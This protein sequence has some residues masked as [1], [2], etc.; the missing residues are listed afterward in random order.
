VTKLTDENFDPLPTEMRIYFFRT[1][2][3]LSFRP[4]DKK[5]A[6]MTLVFDPHEIGKDTDAVKELA[7]KEAAKLGANDV[8]YISST[9]YGDTKDIASMTFRCS[10]FPDIDY[11]VDLFKSSFYKNLYLEVLRR[12]EPLYFDS[13]V[14]LYKTLS[15]IG[16]K[17]E[18]ILK[19]NKKITVLQDIKTNK[20]LD[21]DEVMKRWLDCLANEI[22]SFHK[23]NLDLYISEYDKIFQII[24]KNFPKTDA[25]KA[26]WWL[27]PK[28]D[29]QK[30]INFQN[31][32]DSFTLNHDYQLNA[33]V[34]FYGLCL[35][36]DDEI[37]VFMEDVG[38]E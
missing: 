5:I 19:E 4:D 32:K 15:L 3:H 31:F 13:S 18:Q 37:H 7:K 36:S 29:A 21:K 35:F 38:M 6:T 24:K 20:Q 9:E 11:D 33:A 1:I 30:N 25:E 27:F 23:E 14:T 10:R 22:I 8:Y 34:R 16:V 12:Y 2:E 17:R 26:T 28:L